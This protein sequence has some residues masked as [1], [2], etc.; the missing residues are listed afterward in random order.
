MHWLPNIIL[1]Y[2]IAYGKVFKRIV[3]IT[4]PERLKTEQAR[5]EAN[6]NITLH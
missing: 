5:V 3:K 6:K 2:N 4:D 1:V